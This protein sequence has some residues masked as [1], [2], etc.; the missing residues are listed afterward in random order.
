VRDSELAT[1]RKV[2]QDFFAAWKDADADIPIL[3][4]AKH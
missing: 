3:Q 4:E 1:A 2:Y